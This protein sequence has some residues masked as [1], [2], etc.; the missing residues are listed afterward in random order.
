MMKTTTSLTGKGELNVLKHNQN[1][2]HYYFKRYKNEPLVK[3]KEEDPVVIKADEEMELVAPAKDGQENNN[4]LDQPEN[5][6]TRF[7]EIRAEVEVPDDPV[8]PAEKNKDGSKEQGSDGVIREPNLLNSMGENLDDEPEPALVDGNGVIAARNPRFHNFNPRS[9]KDADDNNLPEDQEVEN[10]HD[11]DRGA[12]NWRRCQSCWRF[13]FFLYESQSVSSFDLIFF[14]RMCEIIMQMWEIIA[15]SL[16]LLSVVRV[17]SLICFLERVQR[18][19]WFEYNTKCCS[20]L[21]EIKLKL[22]LREELSTAFA[23]GSG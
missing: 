1:W 4:V 17:F 2:C 8:E 22:I 12:D 16:L 15:L 9:N 18:T 13:L 6:E 20:S 3:G 23:I 5:E 10:D 11:D 14:P 7:K 19:I 21:I